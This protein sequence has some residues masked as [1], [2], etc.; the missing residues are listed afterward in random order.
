MMSNIKD[1]E[2]MTAIEKTELYESLDQDIG[3]SGEMISPTKCL[4]TGYTK[5][6]KKVTFT[7]KR[8]GQETY[9]F[10]RTK[11]SDCGEDNG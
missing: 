3:L 9:K 4:V 10:F 11:L 6:G 8:R 1:L 5:D 7:A 2:E